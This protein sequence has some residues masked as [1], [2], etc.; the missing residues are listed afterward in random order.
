MKRTLSFVLS[1]CL[2][3]SLWSC[4]ASQRALPA[5]TV[6][7]SSPLE[8]TLSYLM[9]AEGVHDLPGLY[10]ALAENAGQS[11]QDWIALALTRTGRTEGAKVYRDA[12]TAY[13]SSRYE[14]Q[15]KLSRSLATEWHR[16]GL[17]FLALGDDARNVAGADL[18]ADGIWDRGKVAPLT[19]QG[20]NGVAWALIFLG[21]GGYA[22][23]EN[24]SQSRS[25]LIDLLLAAQHEDGG[26]VFGNFDSDADTT[27]MALSGLARFRGEEKVDAAVEKGLELLSEK[28]LP[29]GGFESFGTHNPMSVSQVILALTALGIDPASDERFQKEGGNPVTALLRYQLPDGSFPA[30]EGEEA[31]GG[32]ATCQALLALAALE[33]FERGERLFDRGCAS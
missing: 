5:A 24:A 13:V 2:L 8:K 33:L 18:A 9:A 25:E 12:L 23:P 1:L 14:T 17:C 26:W 28:Q 7:A 31:G 22:V 3:L 16:I 19:S 32:I 29:D 27:A 30:K 21:A 10:R 11:G 4:S 6:P 15:D 20:C